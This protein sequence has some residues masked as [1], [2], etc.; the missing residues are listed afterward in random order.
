MDKL[1]ADKSDIVNLV[2][3]LG[4]Y[5]IHSCKWISNSL[6]F[7][8]FLQNFANN[9]KSQKCI[10]RKNR[11]AKRLYTSISKSFLMSLILLIYLFT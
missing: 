10:E 3:L 2:I 8:V 11:K 6:F 5:H 4:K 9:L 1:N 7:T